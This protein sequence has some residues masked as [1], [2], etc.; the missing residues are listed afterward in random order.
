MWYIAGNR[1]PAKYPLPV[2]LVYKQVCLRN[3][4]WTSAGYNT[5]AS[6]KS[7]RTSCCRIWHGEVWAWQAVVII[8][9]EPCRWL[10][11]LRRVRYQSLLCSVAPD[12]FPLHVSDLVLILPVRNFGFK[13]V[14]V[15]DAV[16]HYTLG[17][18]FTW[19]GHTRRRIS[20][21]RA[22][23]AARRASQIMYDPRR[24]P[25]CFF[26]LYQAFLWI[27]HSVTRDAI[28]TYLVPTR[29]SYYQSGPDW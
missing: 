21:G 16:L 28:F 22:T 4:G 3:F 7:N 27:I 17:M 12:Q 6:V 23:D 9:Q 20:V 8:L 26:L 1:R 15:V 24:S 10:W 13:V 11:T 5:A 2:V 18:S 25:S 29:K 14:H 19:C